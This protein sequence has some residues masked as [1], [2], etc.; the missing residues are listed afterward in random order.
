MRFLIR[1]RAIST[2]FPKTSPHSRPL[3]DDPA[4]ESRN[5]H[6]RVAARKPKTNERTKEKE[7][8]RR[9]AQV[10]APHLQG[11]ARVQRDAHAFRRSTAAP[12]KGTAHPQGATQARA[13]GDSAGA[14]EP[15]DRQPGRVSHASPRAL[16]APSC[17]RPAS[18]SR[19]GHSAGRLMP[20]PPE[21]GSDKPPPAG[22]A[23]RSAGRS[24][25]AGVLSVS[26]VGA[27]ILVTGRVSSGVTIRVTCALIQQRFSPR[28]F[29]RGNK[30]DAG[31]RCV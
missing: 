18:T 30:A 1:I 21:R 4:V 23:P 3:S 24:H 6:D 14:C 5:H 17:H 9:K 8:E 27:L 25:P 12:A 20:G 15:M 29:A 13:S 28:L 2:P 7:A 31:Q 22:T 10:L 26:E 19:T 16:P 11:A